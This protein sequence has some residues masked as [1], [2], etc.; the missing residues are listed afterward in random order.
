[1]LDQMVVALA[2]A[3][4]LALLA[5]PRASAYERGLELERVASVFALREA[6]VRCPSM[7]EWVGDPI[8]GTGPTQPRAWA[9]TNMVKDYIALHPALCAGALDVSN[10]T[11]P[12]WQRAAGVLVLVHEAYH[13][14]RWPG[15]WDEA[16]VECRAI[17]DF[18]KAVVL[19]GAS[20]ELANELLPWA[21]AVHLR[22]GALFPE[23]RQ[24]DC[25]LPVWAPPFSP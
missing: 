17:R 24:R 22:M 15:R 14:R 19:L 18:K 6:D 1:M 20:R 4:A 8:W 21:L 2:L 3:L 10:S 13:V 11:L 23:Y 16:K 5:A 9:Y 7:G 12:G 25:K